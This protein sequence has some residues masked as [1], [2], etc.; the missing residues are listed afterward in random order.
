MGSDDSA[1]YPDKPAGHRSTTCVS[2]SLA[3]A[4]LTHQVV[5]LFGLRWEHPSCEPELCSA[6][7]VAT[8]LSRF[9]RN[10]LVEHVGRA[11]LRYEGGIERR[12][13]TEM[14][15][16]YSEPIHMPPD[17]GRRHLGEREDSFVRGTVD[18]KP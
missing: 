11:P 14:N 4:A 9:S 8:R 7:A 13:G 5:S 17:A 10:L 3:I 16:E 15:I 12:L 2:E 6:F 1:F 18:S